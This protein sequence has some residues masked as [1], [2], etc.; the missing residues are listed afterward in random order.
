M[1]D[2]DQRRIRMVYSLLFSLP[3][4]PVL[5]YGEEIGMAENLAIEREAIEAA[6]AEIGL[7]AGGARA[8]R[9]DALGHAAGAQRQRSAGVGHRGARAD[10][11]DVRLAGVGGDGRQRVVEVADDGVGFDASNGGQL[12]REGHFGLAGM[13]ERVSL[14]GGRWDVEAVPGGGTHIAVLLPRQVTPVG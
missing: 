1:L 12:L 4:T 9:L 7:H 6:G 5:F 11:D 14:V 3:G 2:G 13:R 10:V 8:E